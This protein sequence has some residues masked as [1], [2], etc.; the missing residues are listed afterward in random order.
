[1]SC[2]TYLLKSGFSLL[3]FAFVVS[4]HLVDVLDNISIEVLV[5]EDEHYDPSPD[6]YRVDESTQ[7]LE[8][9]HECVDLSLVDSA[10]YIQSYIEASNEIWGR[11]INNLTRVQYDLIDH[12]KE[13]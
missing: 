1:L 11:E 8:Q 3:Y 7:V 9:V 10:F 5:N 4:V 13:N 2:Y 6:K 12:S